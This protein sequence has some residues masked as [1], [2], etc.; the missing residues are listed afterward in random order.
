VCYRSAV[1]C[2]NVILDLRVFLGGL[3]LQRFQPSRFY[4]ETPDS[5]QILPIYHKIVK[6]RGKNANRENFLQCITL[7]SHI[8]PPVS[9]QVLCRFIRP[10]VLLHLAAQNRWINNSKEQ[11]KDVCDKNKLKT[12]WNNS[13]MM[14][15]C[16]KR[17]LRKPKFAK[18]P[19]GHAPGPP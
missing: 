18:F 8:I 16:R 3:V 14:S 13:E 4:R 1:Q 12:L 9:H 11:P 15:K 17:H 5:Y 6:T 10:A 7:S 2:K 19:G